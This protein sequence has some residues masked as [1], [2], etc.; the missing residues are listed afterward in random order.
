MH[1][2]TC[3]SHTIELIAL[4]AVMLSMM[5]QKQYFPY[6]YL[7]CHVAY[8]NDLN[9]LITDPVKTAKNYLKGPFLIDLLG[10]FPFD[11]I[12]I[13]SNPGIKI[14]SRKNHY[15]GY[16]RLITFLR[17]NRCLQLYKLVQVGL[18]LNQT[19]FHSL[20]LIT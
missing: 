4:L 3:R 11:L 18:M 8:Y 16:Y 15:L 9:Q 2:S 1:G 10:C 19:I 12:A 17:L 5:F 7:M 6:R 13:I 14:F 20:S